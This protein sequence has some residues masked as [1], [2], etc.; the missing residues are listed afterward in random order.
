MKKTTLLVAL[1]PIGIAVSFAAP[2]GVT[3][4]S[5][6]RAER[7]ARREV[8]WKV[9]EIFQALGVRQGSRVAD[10]GSGEGFLTLRLAS[11]V[12]PEGKV[13]AVDIDDRALGELRKRIEETGSTNIEVVRGGE[14]DPLLAPA[15]LDGAVIL[16]AYH[17]FPRYREM[18]AAI[19]VALRPGGRLV[20]VDVEPAGADAGQSR[21]R[22]FSQ[23]VLA[24]GIAQA[25]VIEAGFRVI[26]SL[27]S[28]VRLNDRETVWLVGATASAK[29]LP[30]RDREGAVS[31]PCGAPRKTNPT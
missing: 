20:I 18:L 8:E 6:V 5:A 25:E 31:S 16:R 21:E 29:P 1:I 11:A 26:L 19:R 4:A 28:F 30:S 24:H 15:S 23:H 27:P 12:G 22:Q 3:D 17:E 9:P 7:E 14:A 2:G 13:F 10:I